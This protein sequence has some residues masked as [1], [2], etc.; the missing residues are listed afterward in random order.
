MPIQGTAADIIKKAMIE[1]YPLLC[2]LSAR[3]IL[4]VHDELVL[5]VPEDRV[6]EAAEV[7]V[8]VMEGACELDAPLRRTLRRDQLARRRGDQGLTDVWLQA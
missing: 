7:V 8:S 1:L 2:E 6:H 4:Q 3:M 5:E